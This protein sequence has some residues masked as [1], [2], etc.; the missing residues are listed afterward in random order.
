MR[1]PVEVTRRIASIVP[2]EH[3][4]LF[5]WLVNDF[6]Y[7]A[8]EQHGGCFARLSQECNF[9]LAEGQLEHNW[10]LEMISI[11]TTKSK[12]TLLAEQAARTSD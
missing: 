10:Q 3:R 7:K 1:H 9:L 8:P 12:E 2:N 4:P 6:S 11:L 5:E